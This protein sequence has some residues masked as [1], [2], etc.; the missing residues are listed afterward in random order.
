MVFTRAKVAVFV[1]GCFWHCCP[2]HGRAPLSNGDYWRP[3]LARNVERD[4]AD[5]EQLEHAGWTVVRLW[6]HVPVDDAVDAVE[7]ALAGAPTGAAGG[8]VP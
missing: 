2:I 6:E 1:D 8:P 3:K 7:A 4:N 5:T